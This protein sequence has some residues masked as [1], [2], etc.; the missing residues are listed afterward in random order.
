VFNS[1]Q[2]HKFSYGANKNKLMKKQKMAKY[3]LYNKHDQLV[4]VREEKP[5]AGIGVYAKRIS[6]AQFEE[7]AVKLRTRNSKPSMLETI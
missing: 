6:N 2:V 4:T 3:A 7:F 5:S 1:R